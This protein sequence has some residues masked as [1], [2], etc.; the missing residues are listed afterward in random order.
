MTALLASWLHLDAAER[1]ARCR[2]L[3]ALLRVFT[4]RVRAG[5]ACA[6]LARAE[7]DMAALEEAEAA[8]AKVPTI[9]LR[10]ALSVLAE[11]TPPNVG[12]GDVGAAGRAAP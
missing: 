3:A 10:R 12:H 7:G 1:R 8:L 9:P 5:D 6:A 11:V 4:T 2:S